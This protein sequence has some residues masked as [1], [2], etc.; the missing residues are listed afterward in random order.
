MPNFIKSYF[1]RRRLRKALK[2]ENVTLLVL[3]LLFADEVLRPGSFYNLQAS[4]SIKKERRIKRLLE[5]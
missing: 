3:S 4:R 5:R 2:E 1:S